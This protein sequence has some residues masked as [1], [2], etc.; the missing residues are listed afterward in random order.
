MR[1]S[2]DDRRPRACGRIARSMA[3]SSSTS[4]ERRRSRPGM[5]SSLPA[6]SST[7]RS[8]SGPDR[9]RPRA[10]TTRFSQ[11]ALPAQVRLPRVLD[12]RRPD[13]VAAVVA[14]R[15]CAAAPRR[16]QLLVARAGGTSRASRRRSRPRS[17]ACA[18]RG[19][20]TGSSGPAR[21]RRRRPRARSA[22][23]C[24]SATMSRGTSSRTRSGVCQHGRLVVVARARGV[25]ARLEACALLGV[26]AQRRR[27]ASATSPGRRDGRPFRYRTGR[28]LGITRPGTIVDVVRRPAR[29][30][31]LAAA[32]RG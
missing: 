14:E 28:A 12:A 3:C 32:R 13:G 30:E 11:P 25:D 9:Y 6:G 7:R 2:H 29:G 15:V 24:S 19:P 22:C 17:R 10:S 18:R 4:T 16:G 31:D 26:Q 27:R 21:R 20:C 1:T 8:A 5:G 23:C